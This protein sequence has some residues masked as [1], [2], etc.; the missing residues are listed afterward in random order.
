[1]SVNQFIES[2]S[3]DPFERAMARKVAAILN[4]PNPR[5][6]SARRQWL[7]QQ[8]QQE[9]IEHRHQRE[10]AQ[11]LAERKSARRHNRSPSLDAVAARRKELGRTGAPYYCAE[12]NAAKKPATR[13]G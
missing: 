6:D 13:N 5:I 10:R 7:V 1:M 2:Q 9:L 12:D 8:A 3:A 4:D 11:Q